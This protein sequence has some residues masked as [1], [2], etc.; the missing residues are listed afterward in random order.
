MLCYAMWTGCELGCCANLGS[1]DQWRP[2][3]PHWNH[4][5]LPSWCGPVSRPTRRPAQ[6]C[7]GSLGRW[8]SPGCWAA[9]CTRSDVVKPDGCQCGWQTAAQVL[10]LKWMKG[11][12]GQK[13]DKLKWKITQWGTK[14]GVKVWQQQKWIELGLAVTLITASI[15]LTGEV[16][17]ADSFLTDGSDLGL[18]MVCSRLMGCCTR[19]ALHLHSMSK[20][21]QDPQHESTIFWV[22]DPRAGEWIHLLMKQI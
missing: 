5:G 16:L 1:P 7:G 13:L 8:H 18:T 3:P 22:Q 21:S 17:G 4:W 20:S 9:G 2:P 11:R 14:E 6:G 10:G 15:N 19:S 12:Y